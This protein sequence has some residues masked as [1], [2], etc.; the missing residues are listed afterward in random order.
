MILVREQTNVEHLC[1]DGKNTVKTL[2]I[3]WRYTDAITY[4]M[5]AYVDKYKRVTKLLSRI[6]AIFDPLL[7]PIVKTKIIM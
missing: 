6:A 4:V 3:H 5:T 7:E 1:L 2:G